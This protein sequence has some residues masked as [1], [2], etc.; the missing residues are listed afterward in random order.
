MSLEL[1]NGKHPNTF[2]AQTSTR[3]S[4]QTHLLLLDPFAGQSGHFVVR[5]TVIQAA[6]TC[7]EHRATMAVEGSI[8]SVQRILWKLQRVLAF[9]R[10][11]S[12]CYRI[13]AVTCSYGKRAA[14]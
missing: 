8:S 5:E 9:R 1:N 3:C 12:R 13:V 10:S 7:R 11:P 6:V 4:F 2:K 14:C